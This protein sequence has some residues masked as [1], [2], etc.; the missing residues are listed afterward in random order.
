[1]DTL[2]GARCGIA[3]YTPRGNR[4]GAAGV[5]G[6]NEFKTAD[7]GGFVRWDWVIGSNTTP[8]TGT[9]TVTCAG[10]TITAG[11]VIT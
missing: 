3:Y 11:I 9:V 1:V 7:A 5:S 8:G 4:S 10:I 6:P 2:P